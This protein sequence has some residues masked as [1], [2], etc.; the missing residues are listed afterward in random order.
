MVYV[1]HIYQ[2]IPIYLESPVTK[3]C[4][5]AAA[6]DDAVVTRIKPSWDSRRV[7]GRCSIFII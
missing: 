3:Y 7:V 6:D 5:S 1:E 4:S 2:G